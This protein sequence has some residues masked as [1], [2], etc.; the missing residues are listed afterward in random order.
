MFEHQPMHYSQKRRTL[1][2]AGLT[3][4]GV[5]LAGFAIESVL[6]KTPSA[7]SQSA[8]PLLPTDGRPAECTTVGAELSL[9]GKSRFSRYYFIDTNGDLTYD[10]ADKDI[11][12]VPNARLLIETLTPTGSSD[13]V[14]PEFGNSFVENSRTSI[15]GVVHYYDK[16]N[17]SM[18]PVQKATVL[19]VPSDG[20]I[21]LALE[22]NSN[23]T[24]EWRLSPGNTVDKIW[25]SLDPQASRRPESIACRPEVQCDW[26]CIQWIIISRLMANADLSRSPIHL[27]PNDVIHRL[28]GKTSSIADFIYYWDTNTQTVI[29]DHSYINSPVIRG[30]EVWKKEELT[31]K[32]VQR[33]QFIRAYAA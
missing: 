16:K 24:L 32:Y 26:N 30:S 5:L 13:F 18:R 28:D 3:G 27:L 23:D 14:Q 31:E 29:T 4:M 22:S 15:N 10:P 1:I 20:G 17:K 33:P 25:G 6:D 9:V 7:Y 21:G 8:C 2:K 11:M 19:T 12:G